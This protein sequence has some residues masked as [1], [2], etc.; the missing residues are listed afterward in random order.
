MKFVISIILI[1]ELDLY[2][3]LSLV[4]FISLNVFA[5]IEKFKSTNF[6][7][8]ISKLLHKNSEKPLSKSL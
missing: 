8:K 4:L 2:D 3:S 7:F 1:T 6:L 5:T